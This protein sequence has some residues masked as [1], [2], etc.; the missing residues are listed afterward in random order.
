MSTH[1]STEQ[2]AQNER[3][4]ENIDMIGIPQKD[5][6]SEL[7]KRDA[8]RRSVRSLPMVRE[9][10]ESYEI[11]IRYKRP[12]FDKMPLIDSPQKAADHFRFFIDN[13]FI[14][15]KEAFL[16]M[17]LNNANK[18]LGMATIGI[19]TSTGVQVFIREIWQLALLTNASAIIICHN[20]PSGKLEF[21][22]ADRDLTKKVIAGSKLLDFCFLDHI[23]LTKESYLSWEN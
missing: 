5:A 9:Q 20:H 13:D 18:V 2:S 21:S 11:G 8:N 6:V 14:D 3:K 4:L 22:K 17:L 1:K 7:N 15:Y 16:V 23:I 10:Q 19:G 12:I